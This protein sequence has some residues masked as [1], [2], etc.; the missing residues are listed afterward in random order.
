MSWKENIIGSRARA[1]LLSPVLALSQ[2]LR[3][4]TRTLSR[5]R[6]HHQPKRPRRHRSDTR[7]FQRV[8][9]TPTL[10]IGHSSAFSPLTITSFLKI[11]TTDLVSVLVRSFPSNTTQQDPPLPSYPLA[12]S[13][14]KLRQYFFDGDE[15]VN[16]A[17]THCIGQSFSSYT[18]QQHSLTPSAPSHVSFIS[19]SR[20]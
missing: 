7:N 16:W 14:C 8:T 4:P 5:V 13:L 3:W 11:Y 19:R 20:K 18:Q 6:D 17:T 15:D 2:F 1:R 9:L 10:A 12:T